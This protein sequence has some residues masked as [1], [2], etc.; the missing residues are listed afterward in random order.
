[1][2]T[3]SMV[4]F[5]VGWMKDYQGQTSDDPIRGGGSDVIKLEVENF[6]SL[7]GRHYGFGQVGSVNLNRIDQGAE[8]G[9][10]YV[11]DVTVV[12]VATRPEEGGRV[13]VGWY[14]NAR[15]W[16]NLRQRPSPGHDQY[17]A[18]AR[19]EDCTLLGI[20]DR[21]FEVPKA[22][23]RVFG[24]G[25]QNI[26]YTLRENGEYDHHA[27][28]F[29]LEL[30]QYIEGVTPVVDESD[31]MPLN[32][33][34][35]GPPGTGK[36]YATAQRCVE[37]CD[38]PAE[39]D[40]ADQEIRD[41]YQALVKEGRVEFIT[42]HQSY[43]YEEFVEGLRPDTVGDEADGEAGPGFRL[44]ATDGV[45][46][47]I[48]KRARKVKVPHV[49]VI[50]EINRA[51]VSKVMGE[52][53]TLLEDDKR[54][55]RANE[56][57]VTLPHSRRSF[58]LPANLHILGTMNTADRSI[59]LLD[60]AL[61]RRFDFEELPPDP[62]RLRNA[63]EETG[64]DL[65]AVLRA[66]N[67][68]LE[69]LIDRDHLI[70]HAWL[71]GA[72]TREDV[73]RAMRRKIIPLIAEY[74]YDD[75]EKVR[76]VLGGTGDFVQREPLRPPPG[77]DDPGEPRYRWTVRESFEAGGYE[78]LITGKP[79]ATAG[80]LGV[81][82]SDVY[83]ML[84]YSRAYGATRLVLLYPWDRETGE[85]E[86]VIRSWTVAAADG[87]TDTSCCLDV[88]MIDVGRPDRAGEFGEGGLNVR[89]SQT[90]TIPCTNAQPGD[91]K[92]PPE[93]MDDK[94]RDIARRNRRWNRPA[95]P[96]SRLGIEEDDVGIRDSVKV[97][98][99]TQ[100]SRKPHHVET[101]ATVTS[102]K[103]FAGRP[104]EPVTAATARDNPSIP[105][106]R[107]RA[108]CPTSWTFA[109]E[110]TDS[111]MH[112]QSVYRHAGSWGCRSWRISIA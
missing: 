43:G 95:G 75:W 82:E 5:N 66:M 90:F 48:A 60:T 32:T 85:A 105:F 110:Q 98:E 103:L 71:M 21:T 35:Y 57:A 91:Q 34:L 55:G 9:A 30:Q 106:S 40:R 83:Q 4:L 44:V 49:L 22:S 6:L 100:R 69:W 84:A 61:R 72:R 104:R 107:K 94:T 33:I 58:T 73:D 18:E 37:I 77:L 16:R 76:A 92:S 74:F 51:N 29:V 7:G 64:V 39:G 50:D 79:A 42:F 99:G 96:I 86:G 56:A 87:G 1:M 24:M 70:G 67:E 45:I 102:M 19:V 93:T 8:D 13:V 97:A 54:E 41:R 17:Y 65:P 47:R 23:K 14:R 10:E 63:A 53:V 89:F 78:R 101:R 59:A 3:M 108:A 62:E 81:Q 88:A 15:V 31:P 38:G 36:T 52:L 25:Q 2:S 11:D 112:G 28:E 20:D 26:R 46:K 68:R 111:R 27:E 12:F 109:A 80:T